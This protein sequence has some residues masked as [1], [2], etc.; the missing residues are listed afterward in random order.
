MTGTDGGVLLACVL[1]L[2]FPGGGAAQMDAPYVPTPPEVVE[3]LLALADVTP[4]DSV[5]D[6]G[7]ATS[8]KPTCGPPRW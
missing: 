5:F 1:S 2:G 7:S 4:A 8:S 6:L 3:A